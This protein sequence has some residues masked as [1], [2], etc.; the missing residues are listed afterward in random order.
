[1]TATREDPNGEDQARSQTLGHLPQ[2]AAGQDH[3]TQ[4]DQDCAA[5]EAQALTG[6]GEG[7]FYVGSA[8]RNR[9]LDR[10]SPRFEGR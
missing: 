1:M 9:P 7:V 4:P 3:N 5:A 10:F 8:P 6:A 2:G